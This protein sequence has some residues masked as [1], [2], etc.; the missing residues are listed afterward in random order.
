M[1][2]RYPGIP[3]IKSDCSDIDLTPRKQRAKRTSV[4]GRRTERFPQE[5]NLSDA[6]LW[7]LLSGRRITNR[8]CR[9][10]R[11]L[12]AA[13]REQGTTAQ[14][15]KM[16][17]PSDASHEGKRTTLVVLARCTLR[18]W[19][20]IAPSLQFWCTFPAFLT[21]RFNNY[22]RPVLFPIQTP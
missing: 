1:S 15:R 7:P 3:A 10:K 8:A 21:T 5:K 17:T 11:S 9:W 14:G 2:G 20:W 12:S 13:Q 4:F 6:S 18:V 22:S 19:L 16:T